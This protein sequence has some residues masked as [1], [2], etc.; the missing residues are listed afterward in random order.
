ML[1]FLINNPDRFA[2]DL[3][4][5][6]FLVTFTKVFTAIGAH[7]AAIIY[8]IY[9][10]KDELTLIKFYPGLVII[11][12]L[13]GKLTDMISSIHSSELGGKSISDLP[14]EIGIHQ[15]QSSFNAIGRVLD[16]YRKG[17]GTDGLKSEVDSA[18]YKFGL[19]DVVAVVIAG[20]LNQIVYFVYSVTY[21]Y[22][23]AFYPF[24]CVLISSNN[25]RNTPCKGSK[26]KREQ[27]ECVDF[28]KAHDI[29]Q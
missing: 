12:S 20:I 9:G 6:P 10:S 5:W 13:D 23:G 14:L 21:F 15:S 4:I 24:L 28:F 27:K 22:Y 16:K 17:F 11:A 19:T 25:N 18:P 2:C 8:L 26:A 7:A 29:K 3:L 1:T